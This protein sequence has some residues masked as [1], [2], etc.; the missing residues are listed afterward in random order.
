MRIAEHTGPIVVDGM[1][2]EEWSF[3]LM[4]NLDFGGADV[5][6]DKVHSE[7][8]RLSILSMDAKHVTIATPDGEDLTP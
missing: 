7:W 5:W 1:T 2:F 6:F 4:G 8:L 3:D